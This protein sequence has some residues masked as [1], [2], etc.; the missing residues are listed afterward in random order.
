[1]EGNICTDT[2]NEITFGSLWRRTW[3]CMRTNW[4]K[5]IGV[6]LIQT[7][8]FYGA[9][10]FPI[11]SIL[12]G[13]LLFP[14]TVGIILF[15]LKLVRREELNISLI[16]EPFNEYGRM[17]WGYIR[18]TIFI[19]LFTLLLI[20]PGIIKTFAYALTYYVMLDHKELSVKECMDKSVELM[21]GYKFTL[22]LYGILM[23]CI[24]A[25]LIICT[26][27]IGLFF[28]I[29]FASAFM[30]NFYNSIKEQKETP[31]PE[32]RQGDPIEPEIVQ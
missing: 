30:A 1:M 28:F 32:I 12:S 3:D 14:L 24:G 4:G 27:G 11:F 5:S 16:F 29:P 21:K 22:F 26:L 2:A 17:L 18:V 20:I 23:S 7:L 8:I 31:E 25:G 15:F 19:F 10:S 13:L 9:S 6:C